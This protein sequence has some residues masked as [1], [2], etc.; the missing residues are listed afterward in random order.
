MV[1]H[2]AVS[3]FRGC[4]TGVSRNISEVAINRSF[5]FS[6]RL[7]GLFLLGLPVS[8]SAMSCGQIFDGKFF[9]IQ[10]I[11]NPPPSFKGARRHHLAMRGTGR[12]ARLSLGVFDT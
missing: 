1:L 6:M 3:L 9:M 12:P 5:V 10:P 7:Q 8:E 4:V 2:S 11:S